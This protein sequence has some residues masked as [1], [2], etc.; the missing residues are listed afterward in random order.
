LCA[1]QDLP[2]GLAAELTAQQIPGVWIQSAQPATPLA[3]MEVD[4]E[5]RALVTRITVNVLAMAIEIQ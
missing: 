3:V 4:E 1:A 2:K 5:H